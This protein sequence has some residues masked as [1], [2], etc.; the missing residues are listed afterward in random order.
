MSPLFLG[1]LLAILSS[2][3]Y[4][5]SAIFARLGLD[6][7]R[8]LSSAV[9]SLTASVAL[10]LLVAL[11]FE[12]PAV[13]SVS[14]A[15]ALWFGLVGLVHFAGGR[16]FSYLGVSYIGASRGAAYRAASPFFAMVLAVVIF[17]EV[18]TV[19]ILAG[20]MFIAAGLFVLMSRE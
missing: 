18:L 14:P 11:A 17:R 15:A 8:P 2:I 7:F 12:G 6:Y 3:T 1:V 5:A 9:I 10:A 4:G 20:T 13:F 19:Q 16:Y